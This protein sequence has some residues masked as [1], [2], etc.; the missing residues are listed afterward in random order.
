M[1]D[2]TDKL[3]KFKQE[4][5]KL[6]MTPVKAND[7]VSPLDAEKIL[8]KGAKPVADTTKH[9][10]K[11][12]TDH[13]DTNQMGKII[14]GNAFQDKLQAILK[15]RAA[16]KLGSAAKTG[17]KSIPFLGPAVAGLTT[18]A[19]TGDVSAATQEALPF[20]NEAG[21]IGPDINSLEHK[22]ESGTA[23]PDELDQLRK[24]FQ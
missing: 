16:A 23:T 10:I 6:S 7:Y 13:I 3:L 5:Q 15:S 21:N 14:S 11:G 1:S 17:L 24:R 2:E 19:A 22:L 18:L 20:V 9:V 12:M 8:V 4:M